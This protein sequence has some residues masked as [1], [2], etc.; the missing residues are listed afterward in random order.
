[1]SVGGQ[2]AQWEQGFADTLTAAIRGKAK[3]VGSLGRLEELALQIGL[4][5][6]KPKPVLGA[7][8]VLVFAGD[9]GLTAEGV[10]AY[11][12]AVTREIAKLVLAGTAGIN[13]CARAAGAG[14]VLVDAG[15]IEALPPHA[16]L[17]DRRIGRGTRNARREPA[18]TLEECAGALEEGHGLDA[19]LDEKN[20]GIVVFG[21]IGIGNTSAAALVGHVLT[22]IDLATL[23]GPGA[24]LDPAGVAHKL[25]VLSETVE[26]AAIAIDDPRSRALEALRQF[27]GFEMVMMVGAMMAAAEARRIVIV[28]GFIVTAAALAALALAP[29]ARS[30]FVFAHCSA[31]PGHRALLDHIGAKPLFDLQMRLGEGTGAALAIPLVRAAELMLREMADLPGQHPK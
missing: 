4:V 25:R 15:M 10:T 30:N 12:S 16:S 11:P 29:A 27:A 19:Y 6:R 20:A 9:H 21:E 28:D 8:E 26:R 31:E 7:A 22:G 18:M 24:G 5:T 14:V 13:I 2:K 1:M 17:I 3:P 23:V